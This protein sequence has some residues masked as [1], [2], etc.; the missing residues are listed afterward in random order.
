MN[1]TLLLL[2]SVCLLSPG[3]TYVS[4]GVV[5]DSDR[6]AETT[7]QDIFADNTD[8]VVYLEQNWDR[9]DSLWFYYTTQG[10]NVMPY[11]IFLNLE[12]ADS[13]KL[14]RDPTHMNEYRFLIQRASYDNPDGLPVGFVEDTYQDKSYVGFTCAACHT[15][16]I[17]FKGTGIRIDGAPTLSDF[18][19]FFLDIEK[20]MTATLNDA[21]KF[22]RL[23][24]IIIEKDLAENKTIF[25]QTLQTIAQ[26]QE[27]YNV[28]N[29][30][31][32]NGMMVHYGYGRLDAFGRIFNRVLEHLTPGQP[33]SNPANAPVSYP[34]LWDTPQ[35]DFVQ[36]NGVGN[37]N[38]G[39]LQGFLG[40]LGRN[41]G[42]VLGVFA[43]FDL[44]KKK[45]DIGYRS[46]AVQRN[47]L[48]LEDHLIDLESPVWP[49]QILP[50]IDQQLAEQ[51]KKV[52]QDYQCGACHSNP[53]DFDRSDSDRLL[54]AQFASLGQ[55]Q[56]D[57][58]MAVNALTYSGNSGLFKGED[59]PDSKDKFSDTTLALFALT[60]AT[61]GVILEPD[62][63]KWLI[64]RWVDQIYDFII[65]KINNPIKDQ[66]TRH[67]D[68]ETDA[69]AQKNLAAYKGR[70]LNG[71][72][73][74]APYLHNGSVANLYELFLPSCKQ[75]QIVSGKECR[76]NKFT[77]GSREFDPVKVGFVSKDTVKYPEL[78]EYNTSLPGNSNAGH[79]YA[80]GKTP[81]IKR[82]EKGKA[83]KNA[84]GKF[85]TEW[86]PAIT[87][88]QR[89]ALVEY[90]KQF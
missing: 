86:L 69:A 76:K 33:N 21:D 22:D 24:N 32:K 27:R 42:E 39:G 13:E 54:I 28:S 25:R 38:P 61:G 5:V 40:P 11:E 1:K 51:G 83:I 8:Q 79:E 74:T 14:F 35:S 18:E 65:A 29:A 9:Y 50:A 6:Y 44:K 26:E 3:C 12:Q 80:V 53:V 84:Q 62:H 72:W 68:F 70:P 30:P 19:S 81:V 90:L 43:T 87:K 10:S 56:T 37:N 45:G 2:A 85:E 55:I 88:E 23:A 48:R 47:L 58:A 64:R 20:A 16:Q 71:I 73:A 82:N 34:F 67:V 89:W 41:T 31:E 52:Y 60:K 49:E 78:F 17:N 36:W 63:D 46:S 59:I 15:N 75:D 4:Q 77:M 66:T 57:N 7:Q